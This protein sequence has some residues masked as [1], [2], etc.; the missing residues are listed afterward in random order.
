MFF[1]ER[2]TRCQSTGLLQMSSRA[3][4]TRERK[5]LDQFVSSSVGYKRLSRSQI[6]SSA[7]QSTPHRKRVQSTTTPC[8]RSR[9][10][11]SLQAFSSARLP[12]RSHRA[13]GLPRPSPHHDHHFLYDRVYRLRRLSLLI[14]L[15]PSMTGSSTLIPLLPHALRLC[16]AL[17]P[18]SFLSITHA[19]RTIPNFHHPRPCARLH[20]PLH[21]PS[22][23]SAA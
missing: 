23:R 13:R 4:G 9:A 10:N 19:P 11:S 1:S 6:G 8:S 2:Y 22:Q 5:L 7:C 16:P 20:L 21:L 17:P 15:R 18:P 14:L 3:M 12:C